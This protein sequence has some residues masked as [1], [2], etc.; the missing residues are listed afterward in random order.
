[1]L[2]VV[3]TPHTRHT[4]FKVVGHIDRTMVA[5][6]NN[7]F[8]PENVEID[9]EQI[10]VLESS[11]FKDL[12]KTIAPG[13]VVCTYRE[14]L[15]LSQRQLAQKAGVTKASYISDIENGRRSISKNLAKKFAE[16]FGI[17]PAML[18]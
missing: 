15:G 17:T 7:R 11:W 9:N 1:M 4:A 6:L 2:A 16:I 3:R 5:Y 8:G 14:N 10:D 13:V 18:L 12:S